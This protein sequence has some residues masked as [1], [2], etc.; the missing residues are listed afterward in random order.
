MPIVCHSRVG[1]ESM[2]LARPNQLIIGGALRYAN[3]PYWDVFAKIGHYGFPR[4]RE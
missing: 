4:K 3:A 1:T 2:I